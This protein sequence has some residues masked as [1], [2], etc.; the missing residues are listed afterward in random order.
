M[1]VLVTGGAGFIGSH[2]VDRLMAHGVEAV[3][4]DQQRS[5]YHREVEHFIGS[6]LDMEALRLALTGVHAVVH[7][8]AVADVKEV[9]EDPSYA[10]T[11]NTRGTLCVLE[12]ARRGR[13]PRVIYG[14]T[15]WVY[16]DCS[17]A[18]VNEATPIPPPR[19]LYTATKLASEYYCRSYSALYGLAH[20][21]LRFGIPYGPRARSGAVIPL[22][23]GKA[24][25][26]EP[27]TLSG[28]GMQFRQFV[29]VE[30][31]AE[32]VVLA[33]KTIAANRIYNLDGEISISIREI[34]QAVSDLIGNVQ[35]VTTPAR[36]GD[37]SGK[38][39]SSRQA[40]DDLGWKATTPFQEG[41]RRYVDWYRGQ[42]EEKKLNWSKVD[43]ALRP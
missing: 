17:E 13:I 23:V 18:E 34:A 29:Y 20:T 28:D 39:V 40:L 15:T 22:F 41:L 12:A 27:L 14:S 8:A 21:I 16:S 5:S 19:H 42:E 31:L 37:F 10:E 25:R 24:L 32:G 11:V 36:P 30:D 43:A 35:I 33:L 1:R 26:G 7:L 38:K 6:V 3:I 4:F 9:F 2:V